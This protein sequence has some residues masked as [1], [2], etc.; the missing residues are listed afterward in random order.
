MNLAPLSVTVKPVAKRKNKPPTANYSTF[1]VGDVHWQG[2]VGIKRIEN[3]PEGAKQIDP[4]VKLAPGSTRGSRHLLNEHTKVKAFYKVKNPD[5]LQGPILLIDEGKFRVDHPD[6]GTATFP[7][8]LYS[9]HY[10]RLH[11]AV[12][13][14]KIRRVLD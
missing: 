3:L 5:A 4:V 9:I 6:H 11:D 8:G 7:P 14:Q 13:P 10:Q 12:D 1:A 2:D